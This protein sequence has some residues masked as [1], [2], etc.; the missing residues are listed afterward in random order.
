[1]SREQMR[2]WCNRNYHT[3]PSE[4]TVTAPVLNPP[5]PIVLSIKARGFLPVYGWEPRAG[6]IYIP[7]HEGQQLRLPRL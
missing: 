4:R 6:V 1:M 7:A 2:M 5:N 3:T